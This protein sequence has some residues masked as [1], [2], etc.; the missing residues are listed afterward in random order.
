MLFI[1]SLTVQFL[2]QLERRHCKDTQYF[3]MVSGNGSGATLRVSLGL[4][5]A[6]VAGTTFTRAHPEAAEAAPRMLTQTR[7]TLTSPTTL[8]DVAA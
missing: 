3:L 4:Q 6:P 2:D 5:P 8:G 7:S 1:S